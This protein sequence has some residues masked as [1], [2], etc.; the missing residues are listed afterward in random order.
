MSELLTA[1]LKF[2][3][4]YKTY[5]IAAGVVLTALSPWLTGEI[6]LADVDWRVVLEGLGLGTLRAGVA[7]S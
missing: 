5:A 6:A 7:K 2:G 3:S 1:I 4:G